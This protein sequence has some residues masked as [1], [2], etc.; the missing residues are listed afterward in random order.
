MVV[1]F[2][3]LSFVSY[4]PDMTL[5]K[6]SLEILMSADKEVLPSPNPSL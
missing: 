5:K 3:G 6:L 2:P 4:I 1:E